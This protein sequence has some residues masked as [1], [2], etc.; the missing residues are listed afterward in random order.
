MTKKTKIQEI[1]NLAQS[2]E[3]IDKILN[4]LTESEKMELFD[5]LRLTMKLDPFA[6]IR[7]NHGITNQ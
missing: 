1:K 4:E 5:K 7:L 2:S 3:K 6:Q